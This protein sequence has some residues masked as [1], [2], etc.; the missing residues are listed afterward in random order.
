MSKLAHK[1][2][3][4]IGGTTGIGLSAA[5]AFVAEGAKVVSVG[6]NP[7]NVAA[8]QR[9]LGAAGHAFAADATSPQTAIKAI[10][11][12]LERFGGFH[13][14]YHVAGGSGQEVGGDLTF[15]GS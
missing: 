11:A 4:V 7:G 13:G 14:L 8:A 3:V 10:Q 2:L 5:K 12:A 9:V 6:R 15:S 1:V